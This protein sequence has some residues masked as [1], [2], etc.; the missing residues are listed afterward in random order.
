M[1]NWLK[2]PKHVFWEALLITILVFSIGIFMGIAY[3][4]RN[5]NIVEDYYSKSEVS[6]MDMFVLQNLIEDGDYDCDSLIKATIDSADKVYEEALLLKP[7]EDANILTDGIVYS[8]KKYDLLR[9]FLWVNA[10][11]ISEECPNELI[12]VVY[13]YEYDTKDLKKKAEQNVWENV[14]TDLKNEY[15]NKIILIP[16]AVNNDLSSVDVI[17]SQIGIEKFPA[18]V[19]EKDKIIYDVSSVEEIK[20]YLN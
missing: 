18:V 11:R 1:V 8:H 16:I 15:G 4:K 5:I 19:V 12:P 20:S 6:M 7:Y 2:S 9:S 17:I 10:L 13:F 3:E 14:L